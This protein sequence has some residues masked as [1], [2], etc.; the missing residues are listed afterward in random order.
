MHARFSVANNGWMS[1][2]TV[3]PFVFV[4]V[5][6]ALLTGCGSVATAY[7]GPDPGGGFYCAHNRFEECS[8]PSNGPL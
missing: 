1:L 2:A 5:L 8:N 4:V 3:M 7:L 6:A